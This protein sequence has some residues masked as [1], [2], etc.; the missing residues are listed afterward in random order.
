MFTI[1]TDIRE[2]LRADHTM[3]G[4]EGRHLTM[5][6]FKL[7]QGVWVRRWRIEPKTFELVFQVPT[8]KR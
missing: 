2:I 3:Q 1:T 5:E 8:C 7:E 4:Y 6:H